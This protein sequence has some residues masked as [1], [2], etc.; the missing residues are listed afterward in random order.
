MTSNPTTVVADPELVPPAPGEL[1]GAAARIGHLATGT[2][3]LIV[4]SMAAYACVSVQVR[5]MGTEGALHRALRGD[6]GS[7]ALYAIAFGM[8]VDA[9]W[10]AV[11]TAV[12]ADRAGHGVIGALNRIGWALAGVAHLGLAWAALRM[13]RGT[14]H[15]TSEAEL[16]AW[17][18]W[19]L[20][21][22]SGRWFVAAVAVVVIGVGL[23]L[24][25]RVGSGTID[26]WLDFSDASAVTWRAVPVLA[27]LASAARGLTFS[28]GGISLLGAALYLDP[29]RALGLGGTLRLIQYQRYGGVLLAIVALG[30]VA[31]GVLEIVR[32]RYRRTPVVTESLTPV[33]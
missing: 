16:K 17:T 2:V 15:S 26:H 23:W 11:R 31:N 29:S 8:L 27:Q 22:P 12:D 6:V 4:G 28:I 13:A 19:A 18:A 7:I 1:L 33:A 32:A 20:S 25:Y 10:Q 21:A 9:V 14:R 3:Y 24:L 5:P 30:F